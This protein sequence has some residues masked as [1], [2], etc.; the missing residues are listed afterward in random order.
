MTANAEMQTSSSRAASSRVAGLFA[1]NALWK[2]AFGAGTMPGALSAPL[3]V[4][5]LSRVRQGTA[6]EVTVGLLI[7]AFGFCTL[8]FGWP[9]N[10]LICNAR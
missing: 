4:S 3:G 2:F 6:A 5:A 8:Y 7:A 10:G 9:M 1:C